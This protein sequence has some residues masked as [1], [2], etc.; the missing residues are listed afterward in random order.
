M[1]MLYCDPSQ[2]NHVIF[3]CQ[4]RV[5]DLVKPKA[6]E[7]LPALIDCLAGQTVTGFNVVNQSESFTTI[8]VLATIVNTLAY[9][10]NIKFSISPHYNKDAV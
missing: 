2:P 3:R 6:E 8:R 7:L 9:T 5:V 10:K 1:A 4:D